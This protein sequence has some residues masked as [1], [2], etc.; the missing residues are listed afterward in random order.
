M[1][2][3]RVDAQRLR[4]LW[5]S[6]GGVAL[7]LAAA[8]VVCLLS[9]TVSLV[10]LWVGVPLT[11]VSVDLLRRLADVHR[12]WAGAV[13]SVEVKR[14]YLP[15]VDSGSLRQLIALGRDPATWRDIVW[16][17]ANSVAGV[18]LC[19]IP[20]TLFLTGIWYVAFPLTYYLV[21]AGTLNDNLLLF[22]VHDF[23]TSL[24]VVPLG[25]L[26]FVVCDRVVEPVMR[27]YARMTVALLGPDERTE[28]AARVRRLTESR[29][30]TVESQAAELRRIERDLHDGAQAR[31]VALGMSIAMAQELLVSDPEGARCLM[32]DARDSS[33]ATLTELRALVRGIHPPVLADRGLL[34]G[35]DALAMA[36]PVPVDVSSAL[37]A[38]SPAP[39]EAA[40][41]FAVAEALTNLNRHSGA[42]S[43]RI[44][45]SHDG[46][47]LRL[48]VSDNG[49]GG[50]QYSPEG[51]L[52]GIERRLA[53]FD[54]TLKVI[55]P[56]GGP[57]TLTMEIPCAL[58]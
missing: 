25:V 39:V 43:A 24:L 18:A 37:S 53:A 28:M 42:S 50:A 8:L 56:R 29:A 14:P 1:L 30:A 41:Y 2:G 11:V 9:V 33:K 23:W 26:S 48:E 47:R 10:V 21:P 58:S 13:L 20:A 38:R 34:G 40:A 7:A 49:D 52:S 55:S 6:F 17:L 27:T 45:V 44:N 57:T 3:E 16:V 54:G 22:Q 19:S 12:E 15:V 5:W 35:I 51:G 4:L 32:Q 36:S 31:L 46:S